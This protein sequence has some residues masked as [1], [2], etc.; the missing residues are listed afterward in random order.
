MFD[1][2]V[3][4]S[5]KKKDTVTFL[6][7][8]IGLNA[9]LGI[10]TIFLAIVAVSLFSFSLLSMLPSIDDQDLELTTLVAPPPAPQ[11]EVPKEQPKDTPKQTTVTDERQIVTRTDLQTNVD[12]TRKVP[13]KIQTTGNQTPPIP[14]TG[15][16]TKGDKNVDPQGGPIGPKDTGG[17]APPVAPK[18]QPPPKED[19]DEGPAPPTPKPT[20]P[21]TPK[22]TPTPAPKPTGPISGGV[23]NGKATNLVKPA[24]PPAAKAVRAS[25]PV[26]V[27]VVIS[28][29][30]SVLSATAVSGH[31]LLRAAAEQAARASKFSPTM[32]TGQAVKVSGT[33]VYN[34]VAP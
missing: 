14:K 26:N 2:L 8:A 27:Q 12:D 18:P 11:P 33:I 31:P 23:V 13:D 25:G 5:G 29:T 24:Y 30:G 22:P 4:S 3:E 9:L 21:P 6:G 20:P 1:Q 17:S 19:P 7:V 34:F 32:L 15:A 10:T 16:F 28:E